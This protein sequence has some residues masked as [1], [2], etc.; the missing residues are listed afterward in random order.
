MNILIFIFVMIL[1]WY[2]GIGI[3]FIF[4]KTGL[5]DKIEEIIKIRKYKKQLKK[6]S[7]K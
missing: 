1:G 2:V 5:I 7:L 3:F 4:W 6:E